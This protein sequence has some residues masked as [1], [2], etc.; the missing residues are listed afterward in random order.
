MDTFSIGDQF[1]CFDSLDKKIKE[2]EDSSYTKLCRCDG[3]TLAGLRKGCLLVI[4]IV[5]ALSRV[6]CHAEHT[7]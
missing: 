4:I 2:F 6:K 5:M 7:S 1:D 3:K